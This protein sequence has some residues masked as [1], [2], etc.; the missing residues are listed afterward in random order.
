VLAAIVLI[1][2]IALK[3]KTLE[4]EVRL[5]CSVPYGHKLAE[6]VVRKLTVK[7]A[8]NMPQFICCQFH[9]LGSYSAMTK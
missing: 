2:I 4:K 8:K 5:Q 1:K 6:A 9:V 7:C 3:Y